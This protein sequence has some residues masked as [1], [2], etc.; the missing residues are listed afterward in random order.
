MGIGRVLV[1]RASGV[2]SALGLAISDLRRDYVAAA[3]GRLDEL[4]PAVLDDAWGELERQARHELGADSE[5]PVLT[6]RADLRY[7]GQS[8][9]LT[10]DVAPGA[11]G[12][13]R[14]VDL[15]QLAE[16]F[17]TAHQRR[18][19]YRMD[20]ETVEVVNLRLVAAVPVGKPEIAA[21]PARRRRRPGSRRVNLDGHWLEVDVLAREE[22]GEG[23]RLEGPAVVEFAEATLLLRPGWRALVDHAGTMALEREG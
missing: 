21:E 19:G 8:F 23:D 20:D 6:R 10:V 2:L 4:D 22:L 9:E 7:R 3:P 12:A 16:R 17:G 5:Q 13:V 15:S 18:Y 1:P 11:T 14:G